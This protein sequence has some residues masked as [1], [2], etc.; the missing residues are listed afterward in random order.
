MSTKNLGRSLLGLAL[1]VVLGATPTSEPRGASTYDAPAP[2]G[3][4]GH[5]MV[6]RAAAT[7]VPVDMPAFF[8]SEVQRLSYLSFEPDRWRDGDMPEMNGAF[9]YDHYID[10]E[11][12][13]AAA[14]EAPDRFQYLAVLY[15]ETTLARPERDAGFLPF[16]IVELAQRLE[17][18][19][20]RWRTAS[21][22]EKAWIEERIMNDAGVL[23][24][25]VADGSNPHHATIHFNGWSASAPNP[26]NFSTAS[27]FHSRFESAFVSAAVTP[28]QVRDG[29][30]S[31]PEVLD[32]VRRAVWAYLDESNR[33]V[34]RLY[35]L[36]QD[37]GFDPANPRP[38]A[39]AFALER[40]T[41]GADM[42]R[43]IWY[44]AWVNS[45]G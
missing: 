3:H 7:H 43:S 2:W 20:R 30:V 13:P 16:R 33:L 11:N 1:V 31:D 37:V 19:F 38:E 8:R 45:G 28:N 4:D 21:G 14:R 34:E 26:R 6:G 41:A 22:E 36:E 29:V 42:L 18:G 12:V 23:G 44:T 27:D 40:L 15:R 5:L 24:H 17:T 25:Y 10:L 35:Q 9:R 32:D 39:A